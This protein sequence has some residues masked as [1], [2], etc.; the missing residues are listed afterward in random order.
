MTLCI[1]NVK[2]QR[3]LSTFMATKWPTIIRHLKTKRIHT[4]TTTTTSKKQ[5]SMCYNAVCKK[6]KN[7]T[8][9]SLKLKKCSLFNTTFLKEKSHR[10][11]LKYKH[12]QKQKNKRKTFHSVFWVIVAFFFSKEQGENYDQLTIQV[13][14]NIL[15]LT[16]Q[17]RHKSCPSQNSKRRLLHMHCNCSS[18]ENSPSATQ[19]QLNV[20]RQ[21]TTAGKK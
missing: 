7:Y 9:V 20:S 21:L 4:K 11:H 2:T 10:T 1:W 8:Y 15:V 14:P 17:T 19:V 6:K 18:G 5:K 12:L 16:F 3:L 13:T